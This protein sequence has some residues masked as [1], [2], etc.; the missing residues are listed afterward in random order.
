MTT[1]LIN[2]DMHIR[3]QKNFDH[4]A[5]GVH[6]KSTSNKKK[7]FEIQISRS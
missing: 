6:K 7:L 5:K 3:Q 1:M 2:E 4:N